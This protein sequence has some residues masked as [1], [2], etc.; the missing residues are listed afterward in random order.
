MIWK[1]LCVLCFRVLTI[2]FI[3]NNVGLVVILRTKNK[4][5]LMDWPWKFQTV[6]PN[7]S[8]LKLQTQQGKSAQLEGITVKSG[9]P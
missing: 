9:G 8:A 5:M 2:H 4:K 6:D 3:S 7:A 1:C